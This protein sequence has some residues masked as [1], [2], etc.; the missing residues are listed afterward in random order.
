MK[1]KPKPKLKPMRNH[2]SAERTRLVRAA[3]NA[4]LCR[5]GSTPS[6]VRHAVAARA[7]ALVLCDDPADE[8]WMTEDLQQFVFTMVEAPVLA[9]LRR[10]V[11]GG[12]SEDEVFELAVAAAVGLGRA[13]FEQGLAVLEDVAVHD[14]QPNPGVAA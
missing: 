7:A 14:L 1:P 8:P 9:D 13:R 3:F 5:E 10:L 4:S 6:A 2:R 12:R 11:A